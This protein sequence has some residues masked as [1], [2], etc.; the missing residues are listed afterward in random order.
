MVLRIDQLGRDMEAD[1]GGAVPSTSSVPTWFNNA[2]GF[3]LETTGVDPFT[4]VPV[5]YAL[6]SSQSV[7]SGLCNPGFPIPPS[8]TAIHGITD[9]MVNSA[10]TLRT[11]ITYLTMVITSRSVIVGMNLKYDLTML[12]SCLR[13]FGFRLSPLPPVVDVLVL[14]RHYVPYR[15][16][17]R[18]LSALCKAYTVVLNTAHNAIADVRASMNILRAMFQ[19]YP[20]L[21]ARPLRSLYTT[22]ANWHYSWAADYSSYRVSE[23]LSA[24]DQREYCWPVMPANLP[25]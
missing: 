25:S 21:S 10:P 11:V 3:D 22:Q 2:T 5:S 19:R 1:N 4:D 24:L 12:D 9:M 16:G 23:G 13:R 17:S 18:T 15:K 14:D 6:V 20:S 7:V 8:A